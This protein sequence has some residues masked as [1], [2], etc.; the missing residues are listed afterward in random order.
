MSRMFYR[1]R[2]F[3]EERLAQSRE[4][5]FDS[6]HLPGGTSQ[7]GEHSAFV[8][9]WFYDF[10][11][12]E[13]FLLVLPYKSDY[14]KSEIFFFNEIKESPIQT[15]VREFKEETGIN[16]SSKDLKL[17][18][19]INGHSN[20]DGENGVIHTKYFFHY[21]KYLTLEQ[22]PSEYYETLGEISSPFMIR[23]SLVS[24]YLFSGHY[25]AIKK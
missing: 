19:I 13:K 2:K 20:K 9:A 10:L 5:G 17:F 4:E 25:A 11:L 24:H 18:H 8:F 6:L 16:I 1:N 3:L 7:N 23:S 12:K 15:A 22:I 21:T 14:W